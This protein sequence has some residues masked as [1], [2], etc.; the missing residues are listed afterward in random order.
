MFVSAVPSFQKW[1]FNIFTYA[2]AVGSGNLHTQT[3]TDSKRLS[4]KIHYLKAQWTSHH[5]FVM[6]ITK[7]EVRNKPPGATDPQAGLGHLQLLFG[8]SP[9][10]WWTDSC[11]GP[12]MVHGPGSAAAMPWHHAEGSSRCYPQSHT[13]EC[14]LAPKVHATHHLQRW[15][16]RPELGGWGPEIHLDLPRAALGPQAIRPHL[17]HV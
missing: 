2:H 11:L 17:P 4:G 12:A 9:C 3:H 6:I 13:T 10:W 5:C 14:Y 15:C 8:A 16:Q 7:E 1:H